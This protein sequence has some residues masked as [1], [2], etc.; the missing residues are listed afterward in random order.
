M[1]RARRGFREAALAPTIAE[2]DDETAAQV[3]LNGF[4]I[5]GSSCSQGGRLPHDSYEN[6]YDFYRFVKKARTALDGPMRLGESARYVAR[7]CR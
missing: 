6:E 2:Y 3:L 7:T 4:E 5:L 1:T